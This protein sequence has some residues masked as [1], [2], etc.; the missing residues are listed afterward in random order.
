MTAT[1]PQTVLIGTFPNRA[2]AEQYVEELRRAGFRD[3]QIGVVTPGDEH[4]HTEAGETALAGALTGGTMGALAGMALVAVG[5]VPGV[6]P[7]LAGGLLVGSLGGAA[8]GATAGGVLG[9][10]IGPGMPEEEAREYEGHLRAGRTLVAVQAPARCGEA[11]TILRR[12]EEH[13]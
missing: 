12:H 5:L 9:A 4:K 6:A 2:R 11:L 3:D 8:A 7:V 10:L 1:V 13:P